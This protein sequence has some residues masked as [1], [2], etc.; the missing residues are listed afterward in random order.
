MDG[1]RRDMI[2]MSLRHAASPAR[3]PMRLSGIVINRKARDD[4][5]ET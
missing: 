5:E 4:G 3:E 2:I 1:A